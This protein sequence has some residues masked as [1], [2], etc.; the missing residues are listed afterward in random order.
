MLLIWPS[1]QIFQVRPDIKF[2]LF[3]SLSYQHKLALYMPHI[4][5]PPSTDSRRAVVIYWG[6]MG[7]EYWLSTGWRSKPA[8]E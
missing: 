3:F 2:S 4:Q 7:I 1:R 6:R 5:F 8:Q